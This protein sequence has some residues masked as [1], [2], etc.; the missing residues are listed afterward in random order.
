MN[1]LFVENFTKK[2]LAAVDLG[3]ELTRHYA[4]E[5]DGV[6]KFESFS[7]VS[8]TDGRL[9]S[10]KDKNDMFFKMAIDEAYEI[11]GLNKEK[12]SPMVAFSYNHF[13]RAFFSI[14]E[15][16]INSVN[17]K[18]EIEQGMLFAE[19]KNMGEGDS[20]TFHI[21][22]N[23]LLSVSTVASGVR[24][25][26]FQK[27]HNEDVTLTPKVKKT[28]VSVD[29]RKVATGVMDWGHLINWVGKSFRTKLQQEV[30]D[31]VYNAYSTLGT[32]LKEATF[33]QD[34]YIQLAERVSALNGSPAMTIGTKTAL[35]TILPT[36]DYLKMGLGQE[37]VNN[38]F[39]EAPFGI[40]TVRLEQSVKTNSTYSFTTS[41]D[42]V[43]IMSGGVDRPVKI[44]MEGQTKI[45]VSKDGDTADDTQN[46]TISAAWDV[47]LA[48]Q[49]HFGI[50]KVR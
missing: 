42:Y 47:K 15:E 39:L 24:N 10:Y 26:G 29:I 30:V 1:R 27:L 49:S 7:R 46:Y 23:F 14:I 17:T 28:G 2:Q 34:S 40:P 43:V 12:V 18:T 38:G 44:G 3:V 22:A 41:N 35:N 21:P 20:L 5:R 9:V 37:Y 25:V 36:S 50:V 8:D 19:V 32:P 11:T 33:A 31:I 6:K 13:E 4:Y 16:V 45:R 48:S